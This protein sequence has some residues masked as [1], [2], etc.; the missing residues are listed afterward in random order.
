MIGAAGLEIV[1][2]R[3]VEAEQCLSKWMW[4]GEFPPERIE[5]VRSFIQEHGAETGMEFRR[6]AGDWAFTRRRMMIL[7]TAPDGA[8]QGSEKI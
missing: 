1:D 2:E 3:I 7:A 5:R 8:S 4:P 6:E